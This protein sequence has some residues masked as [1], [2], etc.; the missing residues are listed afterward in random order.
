LHAVLGLPPHGMGV[1][2]LADLPAEG[3]KQRA[4]V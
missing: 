3:R 4:R 1:T 2:H